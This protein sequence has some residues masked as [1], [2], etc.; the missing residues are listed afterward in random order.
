MENL[1]SSG[2]RALC[3]FISSLYSVQMISFFPLNYPKC[4]TILLKKYFGLK[5]EAA[6][7]H[8]LH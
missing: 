6:S 4:S 5:E 8:R 1:E 7:L 3:N 2:D